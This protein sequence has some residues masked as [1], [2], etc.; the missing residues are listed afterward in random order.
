MGTLSQTAQSVLERVQP[1][2]RPPAHEGQV[3]SGG[4]GGGG[5]REGTSVAPISKLGTMREVPLQWN[6]SRYQLYVQSPLVPR[7][8][9]Q[10]ESTPFS[11]L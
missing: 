3:L 2:L 7:R 6:K 11:F 5:A 8:F 4:G 1:V 10:G 9:C